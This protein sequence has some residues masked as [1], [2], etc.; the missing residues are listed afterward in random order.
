[1]DR[2]ERLQL[3]SAA[4]ARHVDEVLPAKD[5]GVLVSPCPFSQRSVERAGCARP[6]FPVEML[7]SCGACWCAGVVPLLPHS[8]CKW[9]ARVRL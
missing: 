2:C 3:Q 4:I 6:P 7:S 8:L 1:M 9:S 5:Q